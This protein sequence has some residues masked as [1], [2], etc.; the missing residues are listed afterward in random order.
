MT[1]NEHR[2]QGLEKAYQLLNQAVN[3]LAGHTENQNLCNQINS[4]KDNVSKDIESMYDLYH[5]LDVQ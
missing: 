1:K 5:T 3:A 2:L 4:V